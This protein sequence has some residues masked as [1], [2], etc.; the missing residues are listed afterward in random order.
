LKLFIVHNHFRPGGVRRLVE[1]AAP[2]LVTTLTPRVEEIGLV[3]GEQPAP[4]WLSG[5][6]ES[7]S[8]VTV[9]CHVEPAVG[10]VAEQRHSP[11]SIAKRLRR[12]LSALLSGAQRGNAVVW[13]HN[14]GLGRNLLLTRELTRVCDRRG[15]RLILHHHDWWFDNRWQRWPEL[16]RSGFRTLQQVASTVFPM[17]GSVRAVAVNHT[18]TAILKRQFGQQ[19][20]WL[21]N[22]GDAR[23][24]PQSERVRGARR[25]LHALIGQNAPV[26]LMPC[27]LV[28]RK[29]IGE[30]L[31]L[32]RW[33][34]PEAW[35]FTTGGPSS[36]EE[37]AYGRGLAHAASRFDW[38]LRLGILHG[39]ERGKPS[40]PEL[41]AASE[42]I[43]LTS[44]QEGFGFPYIE[45]AA[46][47]RPLL[48]RSIPGMAPD[49]GK[50]GF[51]FPQMYREVLVCPELFNWARERE[52]QRTLFRRWS[53]QLPPACRSLASLPAML[54]S[55][56][57]PRAIAFSRLTLTAQ[58]E[59]LAEPASE[60]F[61]LCARLNPSL[62]R[63][64]TRA[65]E[66]RLGISAWPPSASKWLSC[67]AYA[68]RFSRLLKPV[69][70]TGRDP[71]APLRA[72][73]DFMRARLDPANLYPLLWSTQS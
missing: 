15:V 42:A 46:A 29:N 24:T 69:S 25:W 14:Q 20:A 23:S 56:E 16:R 34:R 41:V 44:L 19:A 22:P 60:S 47:R 55:P 49:L 26:W 66:G 33:L 37:E 6:C 7:L 10:Y 40:V 59:V 32:T 13:A 70:A 63:W 3:A 50:F 18:D 5:F 62:R 28:R 11:G 21:P 12:F 54:T 27:R 30:A 9:S 39:D 72:Q 43:L 53:E 45:A 38:K 73:E 2:H 4:G 68:R 71:G 65:A 67:P 35:L 57:P 52:R 51:R 1:V 31:L 61:E 48:A 8:S 58:L 17:G 36:A 64:R